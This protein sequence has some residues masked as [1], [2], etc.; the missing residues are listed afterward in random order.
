MPLEE[1]ISYFSIFCSNPIGKSG[2]RKKYKFHQWTFQSLANQHSYF[3]PG[4]LVT[5]KSTGGST[6]F[7][8]PSIAQQIKAKYQKL[9]NVFFKRQLKFT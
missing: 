5:Q 7:S 6:F 9:G 4:W 8:F 1:H 2:E 3:C